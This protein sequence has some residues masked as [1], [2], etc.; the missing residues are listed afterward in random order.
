MIPAG[1]EVIVCIQTMNRN[2]DVFPNPES[3][4][5]ERF[6]NSSNISPFSY[7]PFSAGPR[8]CIGKIVFHIIAYFCA[9]SEIVLI[10]T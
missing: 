3:F 10:I 6:E 5:P 2:P 4:I 9:K 8:N 7:L 1:V